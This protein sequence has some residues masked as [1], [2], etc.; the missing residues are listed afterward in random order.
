M[1]FMHKH[2]MNK[3]IQNIKNEKDRNGHSNHQKV[4]EQVTKYQ[5][6]IT[7]KAMTTAHIQISTVAI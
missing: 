7:T 4:M 2:C 6:I 5:Y 3:N 1:K